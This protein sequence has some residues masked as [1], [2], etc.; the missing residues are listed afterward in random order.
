MVLSRCN[1]HLDA[2]TVNV[3]LLTDA[4]LVQFRFVHQSV[5]LWWVL[6]SPT[7]DLRLGRVFK[8]YGDE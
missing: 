5:V 6:A 8:V 3:R 7:D 4:D 2:E 1:S